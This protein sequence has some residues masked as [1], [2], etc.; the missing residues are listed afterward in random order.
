MRAIR[1]LTLKTAASETHG[2]YAMQ[3]K[4]G[5]NLLNYESDGGMRAVLRV[6]AHLSARCGPC[7][8]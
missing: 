7:G 2:D 5:R 3:F 4:R 6:F 8:Q 1:A